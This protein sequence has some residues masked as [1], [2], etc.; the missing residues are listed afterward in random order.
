MSL[1][2]WNIRISRVS[3]RMNLTRW[4]KLKGL[5]KK[6]GDRQPLNFKKKKRFE[7]GLASRHL[8]LKQLE[9]PDWQRKGKVN[10]YTVPFYPRCRIQVREMCSSPEV[11]AGKLHSA[12]Q[13]MSTRGERI[14]PPL[15]IIP[16][17]KYCWLLEKCLEWGREFSLHFFAM[18]LIGQHQSCQAVHVC[19]K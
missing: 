18:W 17:W 3:G 1:R 14:F 16:A 7:G 2:A 12:S 4:V 19:L 11:S 5:S 13:L 10:K 8:R 9:T 15:K 6:K